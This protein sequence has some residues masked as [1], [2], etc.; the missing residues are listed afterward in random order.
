MLPAIVV[1]NL[2]R[3]V[4][5]I[6][7]LPNDP[8]EDAALNL[9]DELT[10]ITAMVAEKFTNERTADGIQKALYLTVGGVSLGLEQ[11]VTHEGDQAALDFLVE[12]GAEHAFQVGFRLIKELSQLPEDALVGEYDQ[13]P[14]YLARRL[15]ELFIDICQADPNQNWAGYEKYAL[16]LQQR[17]EVQAVVRLASWLRRHHDNG[18]VSDSDLNAEGVIA[19]A[20]IFAIEGGGRIVAR[21]GQ[22]EFERFVR[23]VRKNKPDFEEGWAALVAKVP[24]QHHPVL[25]DRIASYRRSCTVVQKILT[26]ASMKSLFEDLENYAGS[27]LDAD[28]S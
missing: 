11:A 15:R 25:L 24:V 21:T 22:K 20:I 27:E 28:Y 5:A 2:P 23:S 4:R 6:K 9:A 12:H 7:L 1:E 17:K 19:L 10:G 8:R 26:R 13:D 14:V 18:P 16:Q 3:L